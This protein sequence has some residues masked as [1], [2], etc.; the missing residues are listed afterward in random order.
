[1]P[2]EIY[3]LNEQGHL[4]PMTE[5]RF[6]L[7]DKLQGLVAQYPKLLSGEQMDPNNP[8]RW[9]LIGREQGIADIVGGSDRWSL[10]HLLIDQDAIPT[11]IEA[12][13][14]ENSEIRRSIVGQMMDYAAHAT[15][16]WNV[17]EIRQ[18]FEER[19]RA[20]GSDATEEL[21]ALLQ[22]DDELDADKF[23]DDVETN[24][25]AANLRLLFVADSI[26]SELARVVE[27]L[28]EQM[29]RTE[30]LAVEIKQF[31]GEKGSTLVPRV[32]GRTAS[33][34]DRSPRKRVR[35][36]LDQVLDEMPSPRAREAAQRLANLAKEKGA[37]VYPGDAGFS[38]RVRPS[39][40]PESLISVAW[41]YPFF[42]RLGWGRTKGFSFGKAHWELENKPSGLLDIVDAWTVQ[43]QADPYTTEASFKDVTARAIS[44]E[45]AAENIDELASRL[46]KVIEDLQNMPPQDEPLS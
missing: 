39:V 14:S 8:R 29:P 26:P 32:I 19:C 27:F 2:E 13:R 10:D 43:F 36:K 40:S 15:Q 22:P 44:P 34:P 45:D 46:E 3:H 21:I 38:I 42:D 5:E 17:T 16:T 12:K 9:I 31:S 1:M 6:A 24:L 25:R 37:I 30:V 41:I 35:K 20:E 23:W 7:E 18:A 11:L 4:E 33:A 28:N